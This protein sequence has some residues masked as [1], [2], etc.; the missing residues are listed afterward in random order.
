MMAKRGDWV[1]QIEHLYVSYKR[2][3]YQYLLSLTRDPHLSEDLLSDTFV[4]AIASIG[5]FKG[6]SS[7]KTWL[8]SIA[9]HCWLQKLRKQK[10]DVEYNDLLGL[11]VS[12]H[13]A[14]RVMTKETAERVRRLLS[15]KDERTRTIVHMR[16]QGYSYWEIA[17]AV[18]I[19]ENAARVIDFRTKKWIKTVLEKEGWG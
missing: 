8:F 5:N 17:Q 10:R 4:R 9:R 2:D 1:K 19:S 16:I 11:Y 6:K 15:E 3:V 14:E 18:N 7:V 13:T 12:D